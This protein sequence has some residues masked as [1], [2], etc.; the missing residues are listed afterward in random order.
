MRIQFIVLAAALLLGGCTRHWVK[1]NSDP[2]Q[3]PDH[4]KH[5]RNGV[6]AGAL[7]GQN[8]R[9]VSVAYLRQFTD[10][11]IGGIFSMDVLEV[12][13]D[14]VGRQA[15]PLVRPHTINLG[16]NINIYGPLSRWLSIYGGIGLF[17]PIY[18]YPDQRY[19]LLQNEDYSSS[20]NAGMLLTFFERI[21]LEIGGSYYLAYI[22]GPDWS[23]I[24][25][26]AFKNIYNGYARIGWRW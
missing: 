7:A 12:G 5:Y 22:Y 17:F 18:T 24:D 8:N 1:E 19:V 25:K 14:A 3:V 20:L 9:G 2:L 13:I 21:A 6:L 10:S 4:A 15:K 26:N 16:Y 11:T 23:E